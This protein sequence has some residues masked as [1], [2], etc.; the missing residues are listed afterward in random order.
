MKK[1][2]ILTFTCLFI[3]AISSCKKCQTCSTTVNGELNTQKVCEKNFNSE[4]EYE[5]WI[6]AY[7]AA[8]GECE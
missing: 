8:G 2:I 7:E 5:N 4:E 1:I 3:M 6:S